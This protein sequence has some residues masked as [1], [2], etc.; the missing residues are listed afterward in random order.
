MIL[1]HKKKYPNDLLVGLNKD[2]EQLHDVYHIDLTTGET[3]KMVENPGFLGWLIDADNNVRG[4][5]TPLPDGGQIVLVRDDDAS[6]WR[7]LVQ[8]GPDD[9]LSSGAIGL[10]LDG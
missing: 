2:N 5:V 10:T 3:K 4:A 9:A 7:P 8:I 6:D 1:S